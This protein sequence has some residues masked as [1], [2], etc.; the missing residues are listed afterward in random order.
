MT[1]FGSDLA[2]RGT[3]TEVGIAGTGDVLVQYDPT[4]PPIS[5]GVEPTSTTSDGTLRFTQITNGA[6]GTSFDERRLVAAGN[7][8][9]WNDIVIGDF[10][11]GSAREV[12]FYR[13]IAPKPGPCTMVNGVCRRIPSTPRRLQQ[14]GFV[15]VREPRAVP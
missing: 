9:D 1:R 6:F 7:G 14:R 4:L 12:F 10:L 3:W 5:G 11:S 13:Q 2:T 8:R 15:H